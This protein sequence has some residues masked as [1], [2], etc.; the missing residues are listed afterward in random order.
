MKKRF[1]RFENMKRVTE[2]KSQTLQECDFMRNGIF[3]HPSHTVKKIV[4]YTIPLE[5]DDIDSEKAFL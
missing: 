2:K 1:S 5:I 4:S 3:F